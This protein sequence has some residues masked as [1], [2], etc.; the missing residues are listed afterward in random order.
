MNPRDGAE[1]PR[2]TKPPDEVPPISAEELVDNEAPGRGEAEP[3]RYPSTI[4]G[5]FYLAVLA[6][7]AVGLGAVAL[8]SWRGGVR[9]MGGALFFGA[10][11]RLVL[12][13]VDAGM[14]AVRHKV[15]DA[16]V[17]IALGA[18]LIALATT[19]PEQPGF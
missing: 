3:R 18:A 17:L 16:V 2:P 9:T 6:V 14:L 8:G 5:A 10:A 11:V 4:G 15:L 19:I 13:P 12:R 7:V 1:P